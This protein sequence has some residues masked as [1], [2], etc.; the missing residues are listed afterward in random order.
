MVQNVSSASLA[1]KRTPTPI[2]Q[3]E[4]LANWEASLDRVVA[5]ETLMIITEGKP[6]V[7]LMPFE[8]YEIRAAHGTND[9]LADH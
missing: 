1:T 6:N 2:T 4:L 8:E 7:Y 9:A 3:E 5:G